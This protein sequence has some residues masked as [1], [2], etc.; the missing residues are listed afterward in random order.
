MKHIV[1]YGRGMT[2]EEN[3]LSHRIRLLFLILLAISLL[4]AWFSVQQQRGLSYVQFFRS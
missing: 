2:I 4:F 3:D 1:A